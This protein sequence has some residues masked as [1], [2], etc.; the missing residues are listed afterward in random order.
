MPYMSAKTLDFLLV[1]LNVNFVFF[2]KL[3]LLTSNRVRGTEQAI[4]HDI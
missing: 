4:Q 1:L 3:S 2:P